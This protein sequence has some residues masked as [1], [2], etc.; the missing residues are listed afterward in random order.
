MALSSG[1]VKVLEAIKAGQSASRW[2][3][4]DDLDASRKHVVALVAE[5]LIEERG[6]GA[7]GLAVRL[8]AEGQDALAYR[9]GRLASR[10]GTSEQPPG[11]RAVELT[12][13]EF[14]AVR[15]FVA[16][17]DSLHKPPA[18]GLAEAVL[19]ARYVPEGSRHVL[20][21]TR[22]QVKSLAYAMHLEGL[23]LSRTAAHRLSHYGVWYKPVPR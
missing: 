3:A 23:A 10:D 7:R 18:E 9:E 22:A 17:A 8:T 19:T 14:A 20:L 21:L 11:T 13:T 6:T 5:G 12:P 16:I 15:H 1:Q 4:A 2:V